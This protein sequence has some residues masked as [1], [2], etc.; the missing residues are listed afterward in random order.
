[1]GFISVASWR[2]EKNGVSGSVP[3][4]PGVS[5]RMGNVFFTST[6]SQGN[7]Q[8][9]VSGHLLVAGGVGVQDTP[10]SWKG[11]QHERHVGKRPISRKSSH[12][13]RRCCMALGKSLRSGLR[14]FTQ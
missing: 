4:P 11:F 2:E 12:S 13:P 5:G 6:A 14:S 1:M 9:T 8:S 7:A 3:Q 10:K